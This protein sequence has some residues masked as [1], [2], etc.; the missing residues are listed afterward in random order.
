MLLVQCQSGL[1]ENI[2]IQAVGSRTW[3]GLAEDKTKASVRLQ[4]RSNEIDARMR[5]VVVCSEAAP[6]D[7]SLYDYIMTSQPVK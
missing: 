4:Q 3:T 7:H 1:S 2:E 6:I 5:D